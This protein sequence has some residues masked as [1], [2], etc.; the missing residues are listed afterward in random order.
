MEDF[1]V[2]FNTAAARSYG[3]RAIQALKME[4]LAKNKKHREAMAQKAGEGA[5]ESA[6]AKEKHQ[7]FLKQV[8]LTFNEQRLITRDDSAKYTVS[9]DP[10]L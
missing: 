7:T 6:E 4:I 9:L 10:A 3:L 8:E 2:H 1:E 5:E